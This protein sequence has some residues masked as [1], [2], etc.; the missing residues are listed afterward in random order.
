MKIAIYHNLPSGGG[1]RA[2][3]EIVKHL[4]GSHE[5]EAYTTSSAEHNFCDIRPYVAS[6]NIYPFKP[7]LL[8]QSPLGRVNAA[9]RTIDLY[10]L[11]ALQR[12]IAKAIDEKNYDLVFVHNCRFSQAPGL[13][14]HVKTKS[15]YYCQEPPRGL[16][17]PQVARPYF[18]RSP[19]RRVIDIIDPLPKIYRRTML[20]FDH[21]S[22][23]DATKVLV[24]SYY[25]RE[26]FYRVY[27]HFATTC[28][29][30]IDFEKFHPL[31][32]M[33]QPFVF[34]V[35]ALRPNKGF[36]FLITSLALIS[37]ER[38]PALVI[39]SNAV[40]TPEK[41]YLEE[42]ADQNGVQLEIRVM[43]TD[44]QLVQLYNQALLTLYAPIMEPF[45]FVP[46][47]SMACKTPV[48][49]VNEAGIRETINNNVTGMLVERE[50][51]AMAEAIA[52]LLSSPTKLE[53]MGSDGRD[54]ILNRW[55][56]EYCSER[57]NEIFNGI[58]HS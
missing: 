4:A 31:G 40:N 33:R 53:S 12:S 34:S 17:E 46:L 56:W 44:D 5:L 9:L 18:H 57:I 13:I 54:N 47:E 38:R 48:I 28:Y 6:Y 30:G 8:L 26:V 36:D 35:G 21:L 2:L 14:R 16:I 15:V 42:L 20:N 23:L 25:S 55:R 39:A 7:L 52:N 24:N 49:G 3:F 41:A 50:P 27:G 32:L 29:L 10:R 45:G 19:I 11:D 22:A 51:L 43:I 37:P 1:K 58:R